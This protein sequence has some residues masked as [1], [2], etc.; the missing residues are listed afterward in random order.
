MYADVDRLSRGGGMLNDPGGPEEF[1]LDLKIEYIVRIDA[2][3]IVIFPCL[4][5]A[6]AFALVS[7]TSTLMLR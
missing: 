5:L 1:I 2:R 6:T 3:F 7:L 4:A